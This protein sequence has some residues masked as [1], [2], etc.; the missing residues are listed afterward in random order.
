M[1]EVLLHKDAQKVLRKA[2]KKIKIKAQECLEYMMASGIKDLPFPIDVLKGSFKKYRYFE[3]KLDKDFRLIVRQQGD[4][5][6]VRAAGT[7]NQLRTG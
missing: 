2:Q 7:H 6:H 1:H 3:I 5:F 4:S